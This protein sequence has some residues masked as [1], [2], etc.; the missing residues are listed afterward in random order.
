MRRYK[1]PEVKGEV[2]STE[3]HAGASW[4]LQ[5]AGGSAV[6]QGRGRRMVDTEQLTLDQALDE[7][8]EEE[9]LAATTVSKTRAVQCACGAWIITDQRQRRQC[10]V[11]GRFTKT[12]GR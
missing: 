2:K 10:E 12:E 6:E 7:A 4:A 5:G 9:L 8:E 11:C 1:P 3:D